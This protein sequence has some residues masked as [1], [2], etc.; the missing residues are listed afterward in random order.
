MK[1]VRSFV[2]MVAF[3]LT[4][5]IGVRAES[6]PAR[7]AHQLLH[8]QSIF[9]SISKL[10]PAGRLAG[11]NRLDLAISLPLQNRV[12]L[13][14][15]LKA[16]NDP[17]SPNYHHYLTPEQF[18]AQ[19]GPSAA[20]YQALKTFAQAHGLQVSATHPNRMLLDVNGAVAD[21]EQAFHVQMNTYRHPTEGRTFYAPD[22]VPSVDLATPILDV[23]G[24]DNYARP[25]PLLVAKALTNGTAASPNS[26]SG[27]N[28]TYL[29]KD[30]RAAYAP[31]TA[32]TGSGQTVGLLQFDG[33]TASD[34]TYYESLAGLSNVTLSNVL[35]DG[36]SGAPSGDGGEVE[37][38]LDIEMA[39]SMAPGLSKIIVYEAPNEAGTFDDVLNRMANDN[40]AKQ[41]SCSWYIPGGGPDPVAEQIF[42]QMGAQGQTFFAACG[43][44]DAYTGLIPFP[45]DSTNVVEVGG[46]FLNTTG[47]QGAYVSESVWNRGGGIGTGGGISTDYAIPNW[48]TNISM[49]ANQGSTTHRN[50]PDVALTADNVYVRA[51]GED[52]YVG[53]TSCAAPLWAGFTALVNQQAVAS[54]RPVVGFIDPAL[55]TIGSGAI[56]ANAL[57]DITN[58]NN[59]SPSSPNK[60]YAV[61]G[62]DL[63]TGWGTPRGQALITALA[64]PDPFIVTPGSGF[65]AAGAAGGPFTVTSQSFTLTNIGTNAL[66]WAVQTNATWLNVS[67]AG[68]TLASHGPGATVTVSLN[69]NAYSL[70]ISNY[71]GTVTFSNVTTAFAQTRP[72]A[73]Q[74][75]P[76]IPPGIVTQ[77]SN[78]SVYVNFNASFS[79]TASGT[80]PLDY[81]WQFDSTNITGATNSVLTLTNV[82]FGQAGSYSVIVSNT[83]GSTN[84]AN[85]VLTVNPPPPCAPVPS[86]LISWWQA[87]SNAND[88]AGLNNGAVTG[89]L[90]YAPGEV[91]QA[92][93]F[94]GLTAVVTCP[95]SST[96]NVGVGAGL[97]V[98]CWISP[99]DT[100]SGY[101]LVEWNSGSGTGYGAQFWV[102]AVNGYIGVAPGNLYANIVDTSGNFHILTTPDGIVKPGTF[103]HVAM[104][105]DK[106]SGVC[107]LYCD[108][109]AVASTNFGSFTPQTSYNVYFGHR[110]STSVYYN[111][112][113]DEISIYNRA[114]TAA[115]ISSIYAA[116]FIGKCPLQPSPP[117]ILT[118]P[119]SQIAFEGFSASFSVIAT[120]L[121]P[122]MY[123]W[124]LNTTN[125]IG[126]TNSILALTNLDY[127]QAG[128]YSVVVSNSLGSTNSSNAVLTVNPP[129]PCAPAPPGLV[130]WWPAD[131]NTLDAE[132]FNNGAAQGGLAYAPGEVGQAFS[133]NGSTAYVTCPASPSLNVGA[134]SGLTVECWINPADTNTGYP[135][136]EWNSGSGIGAQFW[137]S[138]VNGV[139]ANPGGLYVNLIDTGGTFHILQTSPG[140]VEA[141][142]Y[143]HVAMTYDQVSGNCVIYCNGTAVDTANFGALTPQTTYNLNFGHR[144]AS[145][146]F[147]HGTMDEISLYNRALSSAEIQNIYQAGSEGKCLAP[148][149]STQPVS[150]SVAIGSNVT[151]SVSAY[152]TVPLYYQ[153][154]FDQTN[155]VDGGQITGSQ[156]NVLTISSAQ[157]DNAG[158][159]SVMISNVDGSIVSQGA[160]LSVGN[161][162]VIINQPQNTEVAQG[163]NAL[164]TVGVD[165]TGPF[166]YQWYFGGVAL[167][168]GTTSALAITN[169]QL[170]SSGSYNV[171]ISSPFG[172]ALSSNAVLTVD[173][174]PVI[175]LQPTNQTIFAGFNTAFS[176]AAA[177]SAPLYYQ[178]QFDAT[179]LSGATNATL[180]LTNASLSQGGSYNAI[181]SNAFGATNS[182]IAVL[183]VNPAPPCAHVP[184]GLIGWWQAESN[185]D[186]A[187]GLDDGTANGGLTYAPGEVGQAFKFD[188]SSAYV[189]CAASSTLDVGSGEGMTIECW[190]NAGDTNNGYPLVEWNSGSSIGAQLWVSAVSGYVGVAPGNIFLNMIDNNGAFHIL[191]TSSGI[192]TPNTFS[193]VA[194]TYDK[195][196]GV[197]TIFCNGTAVATTNFGSFTPQT[198]YNLYFGHRP[199]TTVYYH[200][201]LDEISIYDDVLS[202]AEIEGIYAAG[203]SGKCLG[204]PSISVQ[205]VSQTVLPGAGAMFSVIATG[206][207]PLSYQWAF[208]GTNLTNNSQIFGAQTPALTLTGVQAGNAGDYAVQISNQ[209]GSITSSNAVLTVI[210]APPCD[211]APP[212]QVSWWPGESNT[213]DV[214]GLNNGTAQ[215]GLTYVTGEVG[216]AFNFNGN[217]AYVQC[218]ASASLNV[219]TNGGFT[220]ECWISPG[221]TN[222]GYP[223]MEWNNG[224]GIGAQLWVSAVN[225]TGVNPGGLY[226]NLIDTTGTF[227]ILETQ[228]GLVT[229]NLFQHVAMTYNRSNGVCTLYCNGAVVGTTNFGSFTPQTSY[230]LYFGHR[231]STSVY[232]HGAMDEVSVY[233]RALS[234]A[235][236][237]D[238]YLAGIQGKCLAPVIFTQPSNAV[239]TVGSNISLSVTAY[240]TAPL[241]YQWFFNHSILPGSVG[242]VL[243]LNNV[244]TNSAG[245]YSVL[246]GNA[247][248]TIMSSNAVLTVDYPPIIRGQPVSETVV[249]GAGIT[250]GV[251]ASG[252]PAPG[253]Q[254]FVNGAGISGA[255]ARSLTLTNV[256]PTDGGSYSVIASNSV[257][258]VASSNAVLTVNDITQT[259]T[260]QALS[261]PATNLTV[262][263]HVQP[264]KTFAVTAVSST[265]AQGGT[266]QL[267]NGMITYTPPAGLVG[268][269]TFN[270]ILTPSS[271]PSFS[272]NI[273][274][275]VSSCLIL[276]ATVNGGQATIRFQGVPE[277]TYYIQA[278]TNL[279]NWTLV[280]A[281]TAGPN[282]MFQFQDP[283]A[284][285]YQQRYYRT[286]QSP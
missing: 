271:G 180:T 219:G 176:V 266:V 208:N 279:V 251:A 91:G 173:A 3:T 172:A 220:V 30:F 273:T 135:L 109:S 250:F 195:S 121:Q 257:G 188:G 150:Q 79:V 17:A 234:T 228:R 207:A 37:V 209:D 240:G 142:V 276:G 101:P 152:G 246:I 1:T 67:P 261:L 175:T 274:V 241:E 281:G 165:G 136:V 16:I 18:T 58:G 200:G 283:N 24:L 178:W 92:F 170:A 277:T 155:L 151:F 186:D 202:P 50:I 19:F 169:V 167:P 143:Q 68:G 13:N 231:P 248:G 118:Q 29:G 259:V 108:G 57:H 55:D 212:G 147:Y 40:L 258:I 268:S 184:A 226:A 35:L 69:P 105:Y 125:I 128:T 124:Q 149:I 93:K 247:E 90:S 117:V 73:L 11:T 53:G 215:G 36:F 177:G 236:I 196:S 140:I 141:G 227:H 103:Q 255:T 43:D 148:A 2:G 153:W 26:G 14:E 110:P 64:T 183:T 211:P 48:Q 256:A 270:Y 160:I 94:D 275:V 144:P 243:T 21:I 162:P 260:G 116:Q 113:L 114:L 104:T 242:S 41:L 204:A 190:V 179:N 72:F 45:C 244:Q 10:M 33:Y 158:T 85:A 163:S 225:G 224:S 49:A 263:S 71:T 238:I 191:T 189:E 223:L 8:R 253:Y 107:V 70:P 159:Y 232:Y 138:A 254:W 187:I 47:P 99:G 249:I 174:P 214:Q 44:Y 229:T 74:V 137:V 139:G 115:E 46:T 235:E 203:I 181:V 96:L 4:L 265:S 217:S 60:F 134:G 9:D 239:T 233:K 216:H 102:S 20:D 201:L 213:L 77:P 100:N 197:C 222:A 252:V 98:E 97:T 168:Q 42:Q 88:V 171:G 182:S 154:L 28:G 63:C 230:S 83:F 192:I 25:K 39:I 23:S 210:P 84:S 78:E 130:S 32:M 146:V 267:A 76:S 161:P 264:G 280:G 31:D 65:A 12:V 285:L 111:G 61:P 52:W 86:G 237:E 245:T 205:P 131:G 282:G 284:G 166:S 120:G 5:A 199:G 127:N 119:A 59:T 7:G 75:L 80:P 22:S 106:T 185:T 81:Q 164:F 51:D 145:S 122:L 286:T 87:E 62:F 272:G 6:G 112:L 126:A 89:N 221:D 278:S 156:T 95:A 269:D 54:G 123:Q 262:P 15:L 56:Y 38:S 66:T 194:V 206:A 198:S 218:P 82:S 193:H 34:I 132:G 157:L 129:P 133:F 27:L